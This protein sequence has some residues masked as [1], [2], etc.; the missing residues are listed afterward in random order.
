MRIAVRGLAA[1]TLLCSATLALAQGP[2]ERGERGGRDRGE[3]AQQRSEPRVERSEPRAE[4]RER[5]EPR[6]QRESV[7]RPDAAQRENRDRRAE[8]QQE[9]R[10]DDRANSEER[11]RVE[12]RQ[13]DRDARQREDR[14]ERKE[15]RADK[16]RERADRRDDR[17]DRRDDR[18][19]QARDRRDDRAERRQDR[20]ERRGDR[21]ERRQAVREARARLNA[22]QRTRFRGSF[23][24]RHVTNV[25]IRVRIG[26]RLPR[27]VRLYPVPAVVVG[28]VPAYS[29][30]RYVY[31][32]D[33]IC[34]VDPDTYEI[35]DVIEY[36]SGGPAVLE[37]R[38]DLT[39]SER[40]LIL[41]AISADFPEAD[42]DL[43]LALG[44][45]VP[46]RVELHRFPD[47]VL[48]RIPKVRPFTFV[49]SDDDVV[50]VDP[51]D[52]EIVLV[53]RR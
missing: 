31:V 50:I 51:R 33:T 32:D 35:V 5:A 39:S 7:Q 34:I 9:R 44:A 15:D 18:K 19:E 14:A 20:S 11:R 48:D 13:G 1:A 12:R 41:D 23:D 16:T 26:A 17:A 21:V 27:S 53:V 3:R 49:V 8:Q 52:R 4:R 45:E 42:V 47:V 36:G 6:A 28:L 29:Y 38:L 40:A 24:R 30:Y 46:G 2:P 25:N 22:D 43:R 10:R 37:A